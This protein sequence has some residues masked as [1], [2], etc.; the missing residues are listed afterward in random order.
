MLEDGDRLRLR[1]TE[2]RHDGTTSTLTRSRVGPIRRGHVP[3][4]HGAV[5]GGKLNADQTLAASTDQFNG[6]IDEA[7][8]RL[9]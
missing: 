2:V 5:R 6:A 9:R 8:L 3:P 1:V 7:F 4:G